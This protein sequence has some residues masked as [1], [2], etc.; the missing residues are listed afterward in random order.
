MAATSKYYVTGSGASADKLYLTCNY[1][2]YM[3]SVAGT[4]MTLTRN[5]GQQVETVKVSKLTSLTNS[6][7]LVF[8][9]CT[10]STFDLSAYLNSPTTVSAPVPA[11]EPSL[12]PAALP[13][14][15]NA[16]VKAYAVDS[17]GETFAPVDPG[18]NLMAIGSSGGDMVYVKAGSNDDASSL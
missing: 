15:L 13:S 10:V 3:G 1:A 11:G 12:A 7:K 9:D 8:S 6:D 18:M 2:D 4:V 17:A 14:A 5:V 16:T